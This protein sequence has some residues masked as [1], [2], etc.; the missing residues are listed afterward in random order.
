MKETQQGSAYH[1][2]FLITCRASNPRMISNVKLSSRTQPTGGTNLGRIYEYNSV[3]Q[4]FF[5]RSYNSL[6][7]AT[8]YPISTA[9]SLSV[10]NGGSFAAEPKIRIYGDCSNI[11]IFNATNNSTM[12]LYGSIDA[13]NYV[14][15]DMKSKTLTDR[16]GNNVFGLLDVTSDWIALEPGLN[17]IS[18]SVTALGTS[19]YTYFFWNNTWM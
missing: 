16:L 14:D 9:S 13:G 8:Y 18:V 6:L 11:T 2:E 12:T 7:S 1:R 3:A 19:A 5:N 4:G 15:V 10:Y 17:D